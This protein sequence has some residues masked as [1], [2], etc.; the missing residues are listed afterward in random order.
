MTVF[1]GKLVAGPDE[2][3]ELMKRLAAIAEDPAPPEPFA[4]TDGVRVAGPHEPSAITI[5]S[6]N[7]VKEPEEPGGKP[8]YYAFGADA[9]PG[10]VAKAR[11]TGAKID[12]VEQALRSVR[13]GV[14][15][16]AGRKPP[17]VSP[18]GDAS[19][20]PEVAPAPPRADD[21]GPPVR[22]AQDL[23]PPTQAAPDELEAMQDR[24]AERRNRNAFSS[25]ASYIGHAGMAQ[26][27]DRA[28]YD[29]RRDEEANSGVSDLMARRKEGSRQLSERQGTESHD[30]Q[31]QTGKQNLTKQYEDMTRSRD[32]NS[33]ASQVS[34]RRRAEAFGLYPKEI[35]RISPDVWSRASA[36]DV[37]VI[38]KEL[39]QQKDRHAAGAGSRELKD[40]L[41]REDALGKGS[42]DFGKL[43]E[44]RD[45]MEEISPG[46]TTGTAPKE[47]MQLGMMDRAAMALPGGIGERFVPEKK[48]E[49]SRL[50]Q[51]LRSTLGYLESGKVISP[52]ELADLDAQIG[53]LQ[54]QPDAAMARGLAQIWRQIDSRMTSFQSSYADPRGAVG[55]VTPL[56]SYGSRGGAVS[57]TLRPQQHAAPA[58]ANQTQDVR[59]APAQRGTSRTDPATGET[60]Y[61]DGQQWVKG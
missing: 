56:Q 30:L 13:G 31:Q 16:A 54:G 29:A 23:R 61:W 42:V 34:Q 10:D 50:T 37:D 35:G 43:N 4:E 5:T 12:V 41:R 2:D 7:G 27:K 21:E 18:A 52:R 20:R 3:D 14:P 59:P 60:R 33:E 44:I 26:P 53:R 55:G 40:F 24:A 39:N 11:G 49:L 15:M 17:A 25:A 51:S 6:R 36:A 28:A 9:N 48:A 8:S 58:G 1:N 38:L 47:D 46:L 45:Q 22:E 19:A 32:Y 57:P